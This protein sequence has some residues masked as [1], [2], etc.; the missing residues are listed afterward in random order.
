MLYDN[1][2]LAVIYLEAAQL[3]GRADF[4]GDHSL[5]PRLRGAGNDLE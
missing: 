3:T 2:L 1:A 5:D 4:A